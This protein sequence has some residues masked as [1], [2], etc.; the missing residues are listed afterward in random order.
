MCVRVCVRWR[1]QSTESTGVGG[2]STTLYGELYTSSSRRSSCMRT[3]RDVH[4]T[5]LLTLPAAAA[6][7][8]AGVAGATVEWAVMGV[9]YR[10]A[11]SVWTYYRIRQ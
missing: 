10:V 4:I 6:A 3:R 11:N 2:L 5:Y 9:V 1:T 8:V 7:G